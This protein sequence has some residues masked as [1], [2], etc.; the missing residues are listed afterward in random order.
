MPRS[1]RSDVAALVQE[2]RAIELVTSE[3][4]V[5]IERIQAYWTLS[6]DLIALVADIE[7]YQ[8]ERPNATYEDPT[9]FALKHRLRGITSRLSDLVAD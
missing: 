2:A 3:A 5:P 9:M 6:A 1:I 4:D 8:L 7:E